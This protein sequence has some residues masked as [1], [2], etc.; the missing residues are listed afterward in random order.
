MDIRLP[1]YQREFVLA[2]ESYLALVAGLGSGKSYAGCVR[3]LMA[4]GGR[5][6][7][8]TIRTPN[9]GIVTAP[10]YTMLR[11]ATIRTFREVAGD[12][13]INFNKTELRAT[14]SNGSEV[15]FR[16]T[17]KPEHLRGPSISWWLGD[18]AA[19]YRPNIWAIM[20][21]RLRQFG[22]NGYAF[23]TTTP[24]GR[25]WIWQKFIRDIN[26]ENA[27]RYKLLRAKTKDNPFLDAEFIKSLYDEY[28]GD[29]AKQELEGEFVGF[30]GL[31]YPE[32][33][34]EIHTTNHTIDL[35]NYKQIIAGVDWGYNNPG[36]ILIAGLDGDDNVHVLHEEYQRRRP[37]EEWVNVADQLNNLYRV[38]DWYCDPSK[39]DYIQKFQE[40]G[41]QA[42]KANNSVETGIQELRQRL[43]KTYSNRPRLTLSTS[44]VYTTTEFEQ[45]QW[46]K[47][48]DGMKDAP[49]KTND[50]TMDALRYLI[51][52]AESLTN[53]GNMSF[54]TSKLL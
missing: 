4:A 47:G 42:T 11:D 9:L 46:A 40:V 7:S 18:E 19:L 51:M 14:I 13:I 33:D 53:V 22:Q 29:F 37:I 30:E 16:S 38:T 39:P 15:L 32:F 10:T 48:P 49:L 28:K 44:A 52:G 54:E 34:R 36:V 41:L 35:N 17:E 26:P 24:K 20:I 3:G 23:L 45:Y 12:A 8:R 1:P 27:Y 25:D 31:I 6:G 5:I 21:G 43:M 50:H 2:D